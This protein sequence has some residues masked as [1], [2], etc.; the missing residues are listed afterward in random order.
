[1]LDADVARG[2]LGK[3]V[4]DEVRAAAGGPSDEER[5]DAGIGGGG[6]G[7]AV[8]AS[9]RGVAAG[10]AAAPIAVVV[11]VLDAARLDLAAGRTAAQLGPPPLLQPPRASPRD[12]DD[13]RVMLVVV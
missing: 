9:V 5:L 2:D 13:E 7:D 6:G 4:G 10:F 12:S 3:V 1:M 11:L 8:V